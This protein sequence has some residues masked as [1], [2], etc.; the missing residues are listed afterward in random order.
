MASNEN[1][2]DSPASRDFKATPKIFERKIKGEPVQTKKIDNLN[3]ATPMK[4]PGFALG[5]TI[6]STTKGIWVWCRV[7]PEQKDTVLILLDTEGLGDVEMGDPNHDNRILTLA[8]LLCSTLVYHMK[9]AFDQDAVNKLTFVSEMSKNIRFGR[10]CDEDNLLLQSVLPGFV[11]ALRDFS[12]KLIKD[13]RQISS[14][15]YLEESLA[16]RTTKVFATLTREYVDALANGALPDV[17][18]AFALVAKIENERIRD[19]CMNMFRS[20]INDIKLPL[21]SKSL[22]K[23]VKEIQCSALEYM[24]TNAVRDVANVVE[25]EA[26]MEMDLFSQQFQSQNEEEIEKHCTNVIIGLPSFSNLQ[27]GLKNK[28]YIVLGG[29]RK[30]K[31]DVDMVRQEYEQALRD[32]EPREIGVVLSNFASQLVPEE[33]KILENNY[34]LTKDE[35]KR[36]KEENAK[37]MERMKVEMAEANQQALDKLQKDLDEQQMKLNAERERRD[38]EEQDKMLDIHTK[39]VSLEANKDDQKKIL[40][41]ITVLQIETRKQREEGNEKLDAMHR[42]AKEEREKMKKER[43]RKDPFIFKNVWNAIFQ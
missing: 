20:G 7:H 41:Q 36:E 40:D 34:E 18:D 17:D 13:G 31:R 33:N 43:E 30:F 4:R 35:K 26:Q 28:G 29:H 25:K 23:R 11:L 32:Y 9:G 37:S 19:K 38:K 1:S 2:T 8:T 12:L 10:R 5:Y 3:K 15:E 27:A 42:S 21:P 22:D 14:D 39:I 6:Q 24:R 16:Y